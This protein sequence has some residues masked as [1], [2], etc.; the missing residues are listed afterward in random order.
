MSLTLKV[1]FLKGW[2]CP[3]I[4]DKVG[5]ISTTNPLDAQNLT[6]GS[7]AQLDV[8]GNWVR[9]V[10]A[11][12]NARA[13]DALLYILWN[14]AAGDGDQNHG[15]PVANASFGQVGWGGVQGIALVNQIEVESAQYLGTPVFNDPLTYDTATGKLQVAAAGQLVIAI[16]TRGVHKMASDTGSADVISFIPSRNHYRGV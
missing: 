2:P 1:N 14:G 7:I 13:Q 16:C 9:P 10:L 4:V 15:Y 6:E 5:A 11:P 8:S 12:N 3:S